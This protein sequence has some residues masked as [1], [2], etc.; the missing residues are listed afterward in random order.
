VEQQL[1]TLSEWRELPPKTQGYAW[2]MQAE[3]PGSELKEQTNPYEIGTVAC[4]DFNNGVQI[5][6]LEAQDSEE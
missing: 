5:A 2:Y 1:I 6:I 4:H 3:L